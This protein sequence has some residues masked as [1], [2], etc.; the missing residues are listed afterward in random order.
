M[1]LRKV[2][3]ILIVFIWISDSLADYHHRSRRSGNEYILHRCTATAELIR[4]H[5]NEDVANISSRKTE[6]DLAQ[7]QMQQRN[8]GFIATVPIDATQTSN[9]ISSGIY[10]R[11]THMRRRG[12]N[13][14]A[15]RITGKHLADTPLKT[16]NIDI[17]QDRPSAFKK[18]IPLP[19]L[20]RDIASRKIDS[21][22]HVIIIKSVI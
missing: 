10:R 16:V 9:Q 3:V 6:E 20:V 4:K 5:R 22:P 18:K 14:H 17:P 21:S 19:E 12:S 11:M 13:G 2:I 8:S 15:R 1:T 7:L